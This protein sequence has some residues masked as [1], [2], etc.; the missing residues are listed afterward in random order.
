M[1]DPFHHSV[2]F[3]FHEK[4]ISGGMALNHFLCPCG[5]RQ[6]FWPQKQVNAL[7]NHSISDGIDLCFDRVEWTLSVCFN[8]IKARGRLIIK[9]G[10]NRFYNRIAVPELFVLCFFFLTCGWDQKW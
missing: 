9:G 3:R 5:S 4:P 10:Q 6:T 2:G 7:A 1:Q 8:R